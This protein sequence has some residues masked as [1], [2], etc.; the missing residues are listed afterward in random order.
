VRSARREVLQRQ[1][2]DYLDHL[3][4]RF[5]ELIIVVAQKGW[6]PDQF[7]VP[8]RCPRD[9]RAAAPKVAR[10]RGSGGHTHGPREGGLAIAKSPASPRWSRS[11]KDRAGAPA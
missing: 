1:E 10:R 4:K 2:P 11:H 8:A 7:R 3:E 9:R 5:Q 6:K